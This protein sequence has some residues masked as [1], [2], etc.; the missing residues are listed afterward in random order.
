MCGG[1]LNI[2]GKNCVHGKDTKRL[3]ACSPYT[4]RDIELCISQLKIILVTL[5]FFRFFQSI[6]Y[7]MD[8]EK[9]HVTLLSL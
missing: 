1:Y 4:P 9:K 7:G 5:K 2:L 3:L 6:L 8:Y